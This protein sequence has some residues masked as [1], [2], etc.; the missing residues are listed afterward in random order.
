MPLCQIWLIFFIQ[1]GMRK[2]GPFWTMCSICTDA[3]WRHLQFS[4]L[5]DFEWRETNLIF[6]K[7]LVCH[8]VKY[9]WYF[10]F[11]LEWEN[12]A[13]F[14]QC[15]SSVLTENEDIR[16]FHSLLTLNKGKLIWYSGSHWY[17][18]V[19]NMTHSFHSVWNEKKWPFL[20]YVFHLCWR[21]M[22]A[23]AIFT[24]H[25]LWMKRN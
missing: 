23:F 7:P 19:S 17:N 22:K 15:V 16:N 11:C 13:L 8:C 21:K 14:E 6:W 24:A 10:S 1:F 3:K 18:I 4:R 5:T 2:Y 9:D 12:I 20:N 25:W